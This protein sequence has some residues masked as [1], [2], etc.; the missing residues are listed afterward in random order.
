MSA[1]VTNYHIP[2]S[3]REA[4]T[5]ECERNTGELYDDA[6]IKTAHQVA[7]CF[8]GPS[9][10]AAVTKKNETAKFNTIVNQVTKFRQTGLR[11]PMNETLVDCEFLAQHMAQ[12]I[13]N[14]YAKLLGYQLTWDKEGIVCLKEILNQASKNR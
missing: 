4:K 14:D 6:M 11:E 13:I 7:R 5:L 1:K 3:A 12:D 2:P 8:V 10:N 9:L